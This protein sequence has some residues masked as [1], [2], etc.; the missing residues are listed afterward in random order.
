MPQAHHE[1]KKMFVLKNYRPP[2]LAL[3]TCS[4]PS[5]II[6]SFHNDERRSSPPQR[7]RH[8]MQ[9]P[10]FAK[11]LRRVDIC[12]IKH[13]QDMNAPFLLNWR[14]KIARN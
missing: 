3:K 1:E 4:F 6:L 12:I 11:L 10:F 13:M 5:K 2:V 9:N 14:Q 8:S 7:S